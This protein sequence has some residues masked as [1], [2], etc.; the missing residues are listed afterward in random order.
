MRFYFDID[1]ELF[2]DEFG[3]SF[4]EA[5]KERI[6]ERIAHYKELINS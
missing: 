4:Q 2:E 3:L 1:D 6:V 5:M